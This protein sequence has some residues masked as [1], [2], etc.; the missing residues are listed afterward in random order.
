MACNPRNDGQFFV[1]WSYVQ[2][3]HT[4]MLFKGNSLWGCLVLNIGQKMLIVAHYYSCLFLDCKASSW[5]PIAPKISVLKFS[6]RFPN[7]ILA[8]LPELEVFLFFISIVGFP[9]ISPN[10]SPTS[11]VIYTNLI[12]LCKGFV[13]DITK[14]HEIEIFYYV[15]WDPLKQECPYCIFLKVI[16]FRFM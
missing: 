2:M 14:C 7:S 12:D 8:T 15:F 5:E 6:N 3:W 4:E 16:M 11:R 9:N 10:F 13:R 1:V